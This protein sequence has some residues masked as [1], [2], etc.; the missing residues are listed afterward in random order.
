MGMVSHEHARREL[1]R[2]AER[3]LA[4]AERAR[5][6]RHLRVCAACRA[7][8]GELARLVDE[9]EALPGALRPLTAQRLGRAWPGIWAGATQP[10]IARW[11][12]PQLSLYLSMLAVVALIALRPLAGAAGPA[13]Q[14]TAG[15]ARTPMA[16]VGTVAAITA[17]PAARGSGSGAETATAAQPMPI[18]TPVPGPHG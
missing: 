4:P 18:P 3:R 13:G 6:E 12:R 15:V 5:V 8:A 16:A 7:E 1:L 14:V 11:G 2:F 17:D 9:V 10:M